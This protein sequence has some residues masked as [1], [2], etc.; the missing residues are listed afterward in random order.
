MFKA[1]RL[2]LAAAAAA[3]IVV[4]PAPAFSQSFLEALFGPS[5]PPRPSAPIRIR[6]TGPLLPP[7]GYSPYRPR[8]EV[9]ELPRQ[10]GNVRTMCVRL[11]D[12]YYFPINFSIPRHKVSRDADLCAASCG[13][14]ARVF[15][16]PSPNGE[17][18]DA[19]DLTGRSYKSL[20]NAFVYR[21][22][23]VAGCTCRPAPWS[24]AERSRHRRY[25]I[26]EGALPESASGDVRIV[27]GSGRDG[28]TPPEVVAGRPVTLPPAEPT[29]AAPVVA[30]SAD[31]VAAVE[32]TPVPRAP[33]TTRSTRAKPQLKEVVAKAPPGPRRT[34]VAS[35]GSSW[36]TAS[37]P[38]YS[39]PGDAP[40]RYR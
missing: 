33:Q 19:H 10:G 34:H 1:P 3:I 31:S 29:P 9:D 28:V 27:A 4:L 15:F 35:Q 8:Y 38:K 18:T 5:T 30:E 6:Q 23:Q 39:W 7:P 24:E 2:I 13:S 22:R 32:T 12:G 20:P 37:Q 40:A 21:K 16:A 14:E 26:A 36:L 11:C 17:I 25:A